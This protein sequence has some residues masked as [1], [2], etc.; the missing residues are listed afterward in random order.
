MIGYILIIQQIEKM[1]D[2]RSVM[3]DERWKR[4]DGLWKRAS[5][6]LLCFWYWIVG[7]IGIYGSLI[8]LVVYKDLSYYNWIY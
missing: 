6:Y 1:K 5:W 4:K 3:K 8:Y 2:E 7:L